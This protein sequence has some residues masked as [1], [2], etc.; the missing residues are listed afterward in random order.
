L[1]DYPEYSI[2][3][4]MHG[5]DFTRLCCHLW[6]R[7]RFQGGCPLNPRH[8]AFGSAYGGLEYLPSPTECIDVLWPELQECQRLPLREVAAREQ[9][10]EFTK[11]WNSFL[12]AKFA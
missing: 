7:A 5:E 12:S 10:Q 11:L 1:A 8:L 6:Y 3:F 2:E 4:L 9:P